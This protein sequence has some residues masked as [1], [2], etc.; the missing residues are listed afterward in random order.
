M[1]LDNIRSREIKAE[2]VRKAKPPQKKV[3]RPIGTRGYLKEPKEQDFPS[4]EATRG[5][6]FRR[7]EE[8]RREEEWL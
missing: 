3:G 2:R 8:K 6:P 5:D 1:L 4:S 7:R